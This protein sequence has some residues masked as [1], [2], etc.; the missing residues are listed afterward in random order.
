MSV[1]PGLQQF[2]G[3]APWQAVAASEGAGQDDAPPWP[4]PPTPANQEIQHSPKIC[5]AG[6]KW[7]TNDQ[8]VHRFLHLQLQ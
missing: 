8:V 7:H 2:E 5:T 3:G 4:S 1:C 6:G